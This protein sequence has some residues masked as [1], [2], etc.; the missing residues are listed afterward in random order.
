MIILNTPNSQYFS[1]K[2]LNI[3]AGNDKINANANTIIL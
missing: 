3:K 2:K 1:F